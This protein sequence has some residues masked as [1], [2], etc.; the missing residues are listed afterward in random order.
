MQLFPVKQ[1]ANKRV[2]LSKLISIKKAA[3]TLRQWSQI[4][5]LHTRMATRAGSRLQAEGFTEWHVSCSLSCVCA[6]AGEKGPE[7]KQEEL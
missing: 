6:A 5:T 3:K 7:E 4:V 2:A 1:S